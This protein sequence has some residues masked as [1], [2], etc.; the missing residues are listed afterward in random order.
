MQ[1]IAL[2]QDAQEFL[3]KGLSYT[4]ITFRTNRINLQNKQS[5]SSTLQIKVWEGAEMNAEGGQVSRE[6][7]SLP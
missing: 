6:M 2:F 3:L 1:C 4:E 7:T 5:I